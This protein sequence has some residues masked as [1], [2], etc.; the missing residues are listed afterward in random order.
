[1]IL[2][3]Y[4]D[5][6]SELELLLALL[7]ADGKLLNGEGEKG[8]PSPAYTA[9][10]TTFSAAGGEGEAAWKKLLRDGFLAG[11]VYPVGELRRPAPT[12]PLRSSR[13]ARPRIRLR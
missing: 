6:V 9:V 13:P 1:M 5:C 4:D 10:R 12:P 2:P 3:L 8:A 7:S 11:S